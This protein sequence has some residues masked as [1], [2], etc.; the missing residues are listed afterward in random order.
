MQRYIAHITVTSH[1]RDDVW[2]H[3]QHDCLCVHQLVQ[4]TTKLCIT[5]PFWGDPTVSTAFHQKGPMILIELPDHDVIVYDN[6]RRSAT[7]TYFFNNSLSRT[8]DWV[9]RPYEILLKSHHTDELN[10]S[11]SYIYCWYLLYGRLNCFYLQRLT[12]QFFLLL[13]SWVTCYLISLP[14][15]CCYGIRTICQFALL[16]LVYCCYRIRMS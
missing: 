12:Y 1:E 2:N 3:R 16:A 8:D 6:T 7:I 14:L 9:N 15:P 10:S 4:L 11:V 5:G 13:L